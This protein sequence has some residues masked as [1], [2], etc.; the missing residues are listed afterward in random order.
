MSCLEHPVGVIGI[1]NQVI[2]PFDLKVARDTFKSR[3]PGERMDIELGF[4][5]H[6]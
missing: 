6:F 2:V 5:R 3:R 1:R 4:G